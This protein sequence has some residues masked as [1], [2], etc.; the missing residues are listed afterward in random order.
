MTALIGGCASTKPGTADNIH[1]GQHD[2]INQNFDGAFN[3]AG[4]SKA[5]KGFALNAVAKVYHF[6]YG[7]RPNYQYARKLYLEAS[8]YDNPEAYNHLGRIYLNGEGV[9]KD[10]TEALKYYQRGCTKGYKLACKNYENLK[11]ESR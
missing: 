7:M 1:P 2:F 3:L 11:K 5:T 4:E 9:P 8:K 6:G 10:T